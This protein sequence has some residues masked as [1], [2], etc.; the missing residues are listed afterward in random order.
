[1]ARRHFAFLDYFEMGGAIAR[2]VS[3]RNLAQPLEAALVISLVLRASP[4]R[5]SIPGERSQHLVEH[6]RY[7]SKIWKLTIIDGTSGFTTRCGAAND[8]QHWPMTLP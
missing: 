5:I 4:L 3:G 1:M 7:A 8:L 2:S 6:S